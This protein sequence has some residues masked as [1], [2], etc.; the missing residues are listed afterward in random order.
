[1]DPIILW[2]KN[3]QNWEYF[4]IGRFSVWHLAEPV[5]HINNVDTIEFCLV[6]SCFCFNSFIPFKHIQTTNQT[7]DAFNLVRVRFVVFLFLFLLSF[8]YVSSP[9]TIIFRWAQ[10][11]LLSQLAFN[12]SI[13][14]ERYETIIIII[15]TSKKR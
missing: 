6:C 2:A 12:I 5:V 3:P 14:R 13:F 4:H 1:M 8:I 7:L 15:I 10:I 9:S 11:G